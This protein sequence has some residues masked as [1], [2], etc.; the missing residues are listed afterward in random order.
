M[1]NGDSIREG[2]HGW[3]FHT[4]YPSPTRGRN[5]THRRVGVIGARSTAEV[6]ATVITNE[7]TQNETQSRLQ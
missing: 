6:D 5:E 4:A 3:G 7:L 1:R 2:L